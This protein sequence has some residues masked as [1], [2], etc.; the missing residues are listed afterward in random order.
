MIQEK[1]YATPN[2]PT[3][4]RPVKFNSDICIGCNECV[5]TCQMDIFIPN[6]EKGN[7]P[8][9][10]YSEECWYCGC[11]V[12]ECPKPGAIK[13]NHPLMQRTRWKRKVTGEHFRL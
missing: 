8:I 5:N 2:M 6:P 3:P 4:S 10:L 9:I 13:L 11:C 12:I 7:P 1:V